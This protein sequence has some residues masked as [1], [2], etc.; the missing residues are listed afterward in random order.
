MGLVFPSFDDGTWL[1]AFPVVLGM[2][3]R[4]SAPYFCVY[5]E[6]VADLANEA[7][8]PTSDNPKWMS[9]PHKMDD[10]AAKVGDLLHPPHSKQDSPPTTDVPARNPGLRRARPKPAAYYDVFVDDFI[11]LAQGSR[12]QLRKC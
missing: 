12:L 7:I 1:V 10:R 2:G 4:D 5:T 11:A 8:N 9:T 6:T 3:W